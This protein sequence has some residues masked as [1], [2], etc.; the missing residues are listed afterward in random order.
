MTDVDLHETMDAIAAGAPAPPAD[1]LDR[2]EAGRRRQRRRRAVVAAAAVTMLAGAALAGVRLSA[3]PVD[4]PAG[5]ARYAPFRIPPSVA[6]RP[7]LWPGNAIPAPEPPSTRYGKPIRVIDEIETS[8]LLAAD[9]DTFW[10]V[11]PEAG[12]FLPIVTGTGVDALR[13]PDWIA[14]SPSSIVWLADDRRSNGELSVYRTPHGGGSK[15]LITVVR[16]DPGALQG[17]LYATDDHVYWSTLDGVTRLSLTDGMTVML[18]G[19]TGLVIDG[20]AWAARPGANPRE[21]RN[22][23]TGETRTVT[24]A[25]EVDPDRLRCIPAFC[26][27]PARSGDGTWFVQRPDGSHT[28][29]LPGA[30]KTFGAMGDAGVILLVD[31]VLL[32]PVSGRFGLASPGSMD[33]CPESAAGSRGKFVYRWATVEGNGC[34]PT[35]V[36][37]LRDTD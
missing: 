37:Y 4:V 13:H 26:V 1:L 21:F 20:T 9:E 3:E 15:G 33:G 8:F 2:V 35:W 6:E 5:P 23:V 32:D 36:M 19:F 31:H 7:S 34:G 12:R 18:P 22:V 28:A 30:V 14:V 25:A 16:Q 17:S 29:K 11:T 10:N 27:A 24:P